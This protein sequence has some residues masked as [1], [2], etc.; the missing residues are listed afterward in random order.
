[1]KPEYLILE[2]MLGNIGM[3][4]VI[5]GSKLYAVPLMKSDINSVKYIVLPAVNNLESQ[6][7]YNVEIGS[8]PSANAEFLYRV[9]YYKDRL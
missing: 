7:A 9:F 2:M 8:N 1:L 3:Q 5:L 4:I 6:E